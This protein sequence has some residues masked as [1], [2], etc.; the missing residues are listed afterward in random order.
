MNGKQINTQMLAFVIVIIMV[1]G[2]TGWVL[3]GVIHEIGHRVAVLF[4]DGVITEFQPL[5]LVGAPHVAYA[6]RFTDIQRA[7]ISV[8]G[9]GMVYL[10]GM[11]TLLLFP[12]KW[13]N[14]KISLAMIF[15]VI[16]FIAQ[17][18]SYAILPILYLLGVSIHD[19]VINF[20]DFS[21]LDPLLISFSASVLIILAAMIV[22]KH[23]RVVSTIRNVVIE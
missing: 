20:L 6:G 23:A 21:Q 22:I 5:V 15:G 1:A 11:L 17:S 12:F 16:P 9:A 19:D 7:I 8:S 10:I 13:A 14:S 4:F 3:S 18:V 2:C